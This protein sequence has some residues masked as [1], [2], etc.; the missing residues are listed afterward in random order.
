MIPYMEGGSR[1][2]VEMHFS[3]G[4][5]SDEATNC[6]YQSEEMGVNRHS[7]KGEIER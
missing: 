6:K 7:N 1:C 2:H 4:E 3:Q 5:I